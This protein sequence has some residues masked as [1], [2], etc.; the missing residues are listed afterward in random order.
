L[1]VSTQ[2]WALKQSPVLRAAVFFNNLEGK[3]SRN[4]MR[5]S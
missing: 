3:G 4:L 1:Q 5:V 2:Q